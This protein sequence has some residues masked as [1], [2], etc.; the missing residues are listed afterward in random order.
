MIS[1]RISNILGHLAIILAKIGYTLTPPSES[2][3]IEYD[4]IWI[5]KLR[6]GAQGKK[7]SARG[8]NA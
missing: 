1:H 8:Q 6:C 7:G 4:N 3:E 5:E 2:L